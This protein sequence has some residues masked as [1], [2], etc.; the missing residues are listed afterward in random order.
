MNLDGETNLKRRQALN[1]TN[2]FPEEDIGTSPEAH[3]YA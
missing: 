1:D 2:C 3:V